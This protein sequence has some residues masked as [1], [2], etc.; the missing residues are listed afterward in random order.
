[1]IEAGIFARTFQRPSVAEVCKAAK[2]SG[3]K[4]IHFNMSCAGLPAMPDE[5]P[6]K[7]IKEIQNARR[8]HGLKI[9]GI[10][11][12]FNMCHPDP[13]HRRDGLRRLRVLAQ[14]CQAIGANLITLCTGTRDPND[15]WKAHPDNQT[16][17]AWRDLTQSMQTA[18]DIA[19]E[20]DVFLGIEPEV[21]NIVSDADK[22]RRL[23]DEFQSKRLKI[24]L[25]PANLFEKADPQEIKQLIDQS[26]AL[27]KDEL[28]MAHAKDRD[29]FGSFVAAGKGLIPFDYFIKKLKALSFDGPLVAH[30]LGEHEAS[31]VKD[32]LHKLL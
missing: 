22:A 25:D 12:T 19:E 1:M 3:F 10:S 13:L 9:C 15:K 5:I 6:K 23:L 26:L 16:P 29:R 30:G 11:G 18:L 21:A 2:E 14:N 20:Y 7:V 24:V 28:I 31:E 8:I 4:I 17:A 27:L 32:Y